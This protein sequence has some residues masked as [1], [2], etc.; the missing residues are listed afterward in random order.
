MDFSDDTEGGNPMVAG[1]QDDLDSDD[2][3]EISQTSAKP[4]IPSKDIDLSSDNEDERKDDDDMG[5]KPVI[6]P[7]LDFDPG[8]DNN[9]LKD[10]EPSKQRTLVN[11]NI[12]SGNQLSLTK[13]SDNAEKKNRDMEQSNISAVENNS[14][15]EES[16]D[17]EDKNPAVTIL[18]D[19]DVSDDDTAS[20][21]PVDSG[22]ATDTTQVT[23]LLFKSL[24]LCRSRIY[25]LQDDINNYTA[26]FFI[27]L[28]ENEGSQASSGE[29]KVSLG[30]EFE[31]LSIF[32]KGL[33]TSS[34]NYT[35]KI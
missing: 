34:P 6:S 23:F 17:E 13:T 4:A 1:F 16:K 7:D 31:D 12:S 26:L 22:L 8:A 32:E 14:D 24:Q 15:S 33:D 20:S 29:P 18:A 10:I 2:E 3:I 35:R 27:T 21:K 19:E 9:T 5:D 28:Q 11:A 25:R 30:L